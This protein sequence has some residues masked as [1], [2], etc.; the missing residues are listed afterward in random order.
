MV[1]EA[2]DRRSWLVLAGLTAL[3]AF[4]PLGCE[5]KGEGDSTVGASLS[6]LLESAGPNVIVPALAETEA[7]ALALDE[8]LAALEATLA[9]GDDPAADQLAAQDAWRAV[10]SSW[11]RVELMQLGP[12]ARR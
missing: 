6:A 12:W 8:A 2:G 7:K 9:A 5:R 4:Q 1:T 3:A 11:Q 10:M